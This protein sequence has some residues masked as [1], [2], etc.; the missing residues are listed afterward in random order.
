MGRSELDSENGSE[1]YG[2]V[3]RIWHVAEVRNLW[4]GPTE[5]VKMAKLTRAEKDARALVRQ[6]FKSGFTLS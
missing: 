5:S 1:I 4:G 3:S 6:V 2:M